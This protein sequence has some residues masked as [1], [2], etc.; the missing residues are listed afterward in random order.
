MKNK[1]YEKEL[2]KGGTP[3]VKAVSSNELPSI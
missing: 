1:Q 2:L 3:P